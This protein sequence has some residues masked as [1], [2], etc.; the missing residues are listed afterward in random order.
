MPQTKLCIVDC[1]I[2][3]LLNIP[4]SGSGLFQIQSRTSPFCN[5]SLAWWGWRVLGEEK[6]EKWQLI[7][8][9]C[10]KSLILSVSA[11]CVWKISNEMFGRCQR[12]WKHLAPVWQSC[13]TAGTNL[14]EKQVISQPPNSLIPS[15]H[16]VRTNGETMQTFYCRPNYK[17]GS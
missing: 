12:C 7:F 4:K 17:W 2:S 15:C 14:Q 11:H 10:F 1:L 3:R 8:W 9:S 6:L 13:Q 5:T 16:A